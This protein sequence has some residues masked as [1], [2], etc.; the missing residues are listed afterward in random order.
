MQAAYGFSH[1]QKACFFAEE[2]LL[3]ETFSPVLLATEEI[4]QE[5]IREKQQRALKAFA[6]MAEDTAGPMDEDIA[7][8]VKSHWNHA[9]NEAEKERKRVLNQL[10]QEIERIPVQLAMIMQLMVAIRKL[11]AE[12]ESNRTKTDAKTNFSQNRYLNLVEQN[13]ILKALY[14]NSKVKWHEHK[15]YVLTWLKE[16]IEKDETFMS[17]QDRKSTTFEDDTEIVAFLIKKKILKSESTQLF[18]EEND[19]LWQENRPVIRSMVNRLVKD[20]R[21]EDEYLP[22][23]IITVNWDEDKEFLM[24]LYNRTTIHNDEFEEIIGRNSKN[25]D[26]ERIALTDRIILRMAM[27]EL[28]HFPTIPIK[29]SINEYIEISKKYST[30]KSKQFVNGMLDTIVIEMKKKGLILKSGRGLMDN[31]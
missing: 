10:I 15:D 27:N 16:I 24:N 8:E 13:E 11:Y 18:F 25:W 28:A 20:V 19:M 9:L 7:A 31:R 26:I 1:I 5:E 29:V 30:P 23:P 14:A 21:E 17:Y 2:E 4:T 22:E 3:K 12:R 6:S